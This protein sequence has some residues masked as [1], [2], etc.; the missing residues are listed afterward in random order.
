VF[1]DARGLPIRV[2]VALR[3]RAPIVQTSNA[4]PAELTIALEAGLELTGFVTTRGG[5]EAVEGAEIILRGP[6][7]DLKA[8]TDKDGSYRL[9]DVAAGALRVSVT[10]AGFVAFERS[11]R[12][13]RPA[14]ADRPI[15]LSPIDLAEGGAVS[16]EV[17]DEHGEPVPGARVARG[18]VPLQVPNARALPGLAL[19]NQR[20]EFKLG[21]LPEGEITLEAFA[22]ET[23]RGHATVSVSRGSTSERVRIALARE[24]ASSRD[25][26]SAGVALTLSDTLEG[27]AALV[28]AVVPNSEAERAGLMRGDRIVAIDGQSVKSV[29]EAKTRLA[30]PVSDDV[31]LELVRGADERVR[32]RVPRERLIE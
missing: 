19:T 16:G 12:I 15:V 7:G 1:S 21:D 14:R 30:G 28:T 13:E 2:S 4:A 11:E 6:G 8:R 17:V 10:H 9:R 3:G 18:A 22:P 27:R 24:S 32:L 20:G 26:P 29:A 25:A 23:G 5:R 31:I